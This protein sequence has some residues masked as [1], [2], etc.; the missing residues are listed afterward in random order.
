MP[1]G[2]AVEGWCGHLFLETQ[3]ELKAVDSVLIDGGVFANS[4]SSQYFG[5][6]GVGRRLSVP[7]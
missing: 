4:L 2:G 3:Q 6:T 1:V 7:E 5:K